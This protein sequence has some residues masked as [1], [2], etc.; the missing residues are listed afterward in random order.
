MRRTVGSGC[1]VKASCQEVRSLGSGG[2][3]AIF[4]EEVG[5]YRWG[6]IGLFKWLCLGD[7]GQVDV[8]IVQVRLVP[9]DIDFT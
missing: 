3:E 2:R 1:C 9:R 6:G 5:C 7:A 8:E 4:V